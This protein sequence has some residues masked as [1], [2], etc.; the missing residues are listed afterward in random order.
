MKVGVHPFLIR[1]SHV[2]S[3]YEKGMFSAPNEQ[4][5]SEIYTVVVG[6]DSRSRNRSLNSEA[7]KIL[8]T[9]GRQ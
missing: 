9:T 2:D 4:S 5:N 6:R 8:S 3:E 7:L 1:D